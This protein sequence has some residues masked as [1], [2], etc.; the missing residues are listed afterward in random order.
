MRKKLAYVKGAVWD[1][2]GGPWRM[3]RP[4]PLGQPIMQN[5][6]A[7]IPTVQRG[8]TVTMVYQDKNFTVSIPGEAL[9]DGAAG[10]T[11]P[12]RNLQSKKQLRVTVRDGLTIVVR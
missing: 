11:I 8:A 5:D 9:S 6:V 4:V 12:V 7:V 3:Q 2:K 1:G 10:E